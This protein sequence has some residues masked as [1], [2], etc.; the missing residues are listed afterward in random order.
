MSG[1]GTWIIVPAYNEA[2]VIDGVVR[3]LCTHHRVIV[4]DDGSRDRTAEAAREAGAT[5]LRHAINLGQG[6]ALQTGIS[7]ALA[8][9]ADRIVTFDGDGQHDVTDIDRLVQALDAAGADV[10]IG[11]RFTG[12]ALGM[13]PTRRLLLRAARVFTRL[14]VGTNLT[15]PHNGLRC[16]TGEAAARV[17]IRQNRMAHA[18]ELVE[19]FSRLKLRVVEVPSTVTYTPYS[20]A[21]G[22]RA[23]NALRIVAELLAGRLYR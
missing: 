8:R 11:N 4:V 20:L 6:A 12:R 22:Q 15:D 23:G 1:T 14:T 18:S 16:L 7:H 5:V 9:G 2:T 3:A 19:Q 17:A 13:P 10:A 21:K